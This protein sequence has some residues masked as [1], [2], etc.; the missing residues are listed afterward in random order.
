ML[1]AKASSAKDLPKFAVKIIQQAR[2]MP[3]ELRERR[4]KIGEVDERK[5]FDE[6]RD[7]FTRELKVE[8]HVHGEDEDE[9]YDPKG[10]AK[11]AEPYRPAIF[12][13]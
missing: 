5:T 7:F 13:E 10:R 1:A 2:T 6:A 4:L 11:L 9:M 12:V 8:V 3:A